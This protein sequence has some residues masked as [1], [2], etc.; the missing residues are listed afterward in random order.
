MVTQAISAI[1]GSELKRAV[2]SLEAQHGSI[3]RAL[4]LL[5]G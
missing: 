3:T 1:A 2:M 4:D 5:L